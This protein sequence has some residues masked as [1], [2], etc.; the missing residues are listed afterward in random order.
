MRAISFAARIEVLG[1]A[2]NPTRD[3]VSWLC[4][5]DT[6]LWNP[7]EEKVIKSFYFEQNLGASGAFWV[8]QNLFRV[9]VCTKY[10]FAVVP[11]WL[12]Q[13]RKHVSGRRTVCDSHLCK[14]KRGQAL[15]RLL[16]LFVTFSFKKRK[17]GERTV[18]DACPYKVWKKSL[19]GE[20]WISPCVPKE[21][22]DIKRVFCRFFAK[23]YCKY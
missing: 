8:Y 6:P 20:G 21:K 7:I 16:L 23:K 3:A 12:A 4:Q 22:V 9:Y 5:R 10:I 11:P 1:L 19:M 2:P 17:L 18:G 13:R 15:R 14:M